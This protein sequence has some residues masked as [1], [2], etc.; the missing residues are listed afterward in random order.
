MDEVGSDPARDRSAA[1]L[2]MPDSD[3]VDAMC[4]TKW[5]SDVTPESKT[6]GRS[7]SAFSSA[8]VHLR[9]VVG[10]LGRHMWRQAT[11]LSSPDWPPKWLNAL[12]ALWVLWLGILIIWL[13]VVIIIPV[14]IKIIVAL[15]LTTS[16]LVSGTKWAEVLSKP[17]H[18]YLDIH[19]ASLPFSPQQLFSFWILFGI[20]LFF[21]SFRGSI[22]GHIGWAVFGLAT[23]AMVW[24]GTSEPSRWLA[25]GLTAVLWSLL[26]ILAYRKRDRT[27]ATATNRRKRF[28]EFLATIERRAEQNA[29]VLGYTNLADYLD[30]KANES[31]DVIALDLGIPDES[32]SALLYRRFPQGVPSRSKTSPKDRR[33]I[34][35]EVLTGGKSRAEMARRYDISPST[36]SKLVKDHEGREAN[37]KANLDKRD[38]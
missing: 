13:V 18:S 17:V 8:F 26:S 19:S 5:T 32:V 24:S 7:S 20:I 10:K 9:A 36:V 28:P 14:F 29:S 6:K 15:G 34:V 27:S 3:G 2:R 37:K 31:L 4:Q 30:N 33:D 35:N 1:E 25:A 22:G 23:S 16:V 38:G 12:A 21:S 11:D